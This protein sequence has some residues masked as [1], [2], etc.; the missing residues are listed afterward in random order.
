MVMGSRLDT[1]SNLPGSG[2]GSSTTEG[3]VEVVQGVWRSAEMIQ[4]ELGEV[5]FCHF[6]C[7]AVVACIAR[8]LGYLSGR[9]LRLFS[10]GWDDVM[11]KGVVYCVEG[12]VG[13]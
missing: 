7:R 3:I 6:I 13:R 10:A 8:G 11:G 1:S 5:H 12:K 4:R 2:L 9:Y